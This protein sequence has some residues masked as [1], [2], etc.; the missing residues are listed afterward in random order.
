[1]AWPRFG[2]VRPGDSIPMSTGYVKIMASNGGAYVN[3]GQVISVATLNSGAYKPPGL[4]QPKTTLPKLYNK[5][6]GLGSANAVPAVLKAQ[7]N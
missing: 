7:G 3:P 6:V 2:Q 4:V 1:M 5:N